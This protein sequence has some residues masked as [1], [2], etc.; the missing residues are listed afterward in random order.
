MTAFRPRAHLDSREGATDHALLDREVCAR[1][2]GSPLHRPGSTVLMVSDPRFTEFANRIAA[3]CVRLGVRHTIDPQSPP[4]T[5]KVQVANLCPNSQ[6]LQAS[7]RH[8]GI[9]SVRSNSKVP[10]DFDI[11]DKFVASYH[12]AG[13]VD[14]PVSRIGSFF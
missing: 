10:A 9:S 4:E 12:E 14:F 7:R 6:R 8:P 13:P 11:S 3:Q 5:L 2:N 1:D